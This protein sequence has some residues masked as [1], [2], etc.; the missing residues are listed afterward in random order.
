MLKKSEIAERAETANHKFREAERLERRR[1]VDWSERALNPLNASR[2]R[3]EGERL[4]AAPEQL[5]GHAT[6]ELVPANE[7]DA[8]GS[9]ARLCLLETLREPNTISVAAS[10]QRAYAATR[11]NVLA[12]ALD[13][14]VTAGARNSIEKMLCHQLAALHMTGMELL[15]KMQEGALSQLLVVDAVRL[16][17]AAARLFEVYQSGC[18]A[19][20]KLKTGGKQHVVVQY[21]Q[22]NVAQGG[23]A[24]VAGR[25]GR[26]ARRKRG[27]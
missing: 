21:Q 26:P 17:N 10:D 7:P 9:Q 13:T 18:S 3:E 5:E 12:P 25:V 23:Q 1:P 15:V 2:A 4:L 24:V 20:H 14:A 22:V 11:A 19:L 16:T 6:T 27:R 8:P